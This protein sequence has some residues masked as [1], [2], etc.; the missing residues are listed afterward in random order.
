M[1]ESAEDMVRYIQEEIMPTIT[2][3]LSVMFETNPSNRL[4]W[5]GNWL[6]L[7]NVKGTDE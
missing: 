6:L 5:F 7:K 1:N 4:R 2:E 3:G